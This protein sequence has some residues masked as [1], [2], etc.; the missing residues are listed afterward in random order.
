MPN[1]PNA[2]NKDDIKLTITAIA[3]T[4]VLAFWNFLSAGGRKTV[5]AASAPATN[6]AATTLEP[7]VPQMTP[8]KLLLGGPAPK[9]TIVV[10][11]PSVTQPSVT[12]P[13]SQR[14]APPPVTRT[15]SSK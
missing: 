4:L 14:S 13:R 12:Q 15:G 3:F 6:V 2:R 8:V 5:Q 10:T 11:Q 1:K 7:N 9:T